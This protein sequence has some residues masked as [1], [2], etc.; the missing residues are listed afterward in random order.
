MYFINFLI[1]FN[2]LLMLLRLVIIFNVLYL[3]FLNVLSLMSIVV[4]DFYVFILTILYKKC[5]TSKKEKNNNCLLKMHLKVLEALI[6][7]LC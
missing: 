5:F 7:D 1:K 4:C 3:S 2:F 6:I